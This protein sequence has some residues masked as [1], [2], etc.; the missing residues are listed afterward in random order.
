MPEHHLTNRTDRPVGYYRM[1][2][3]RQDASIERQREGVLPYAKRKYGALLAEYQDE[4]IAGDEFDRRSGFQRLLRDAQAGKFNVLVVDEP[5][6]LS[7]QNLI[8]LVEK[9]IAPLRR[10]RVRIDTVSKGELDYESLPGI[11][12]MAVHAH[13]ASEEVND[14]SRRTLGGMA[15]L[16]QAGRWFGWACPYGLRVIRDVD[17]AT[18]K[19]LS[20]R[21]VFGPD[22][23]VRAVRFIFD[24]VAN[25]GWSLRRVCRELEARRVKPPVGNGRGKNKAGGLWNTPTVRNILKNRK[26][27]GDLP[28]NQRRQGKY[29]AW[30]DG[31]V[32]P[33][34][35]QKQKA[36]RSAP[37]DVVI[38]EVSADV[39][40]PLIDRDTF[41]RAQAALARQQKQTSPNRE[42]NAYL[43]THLAVCGD[44]GSFMRGHPLPA[45]KSYLCSHYKEYGNKA[46]HRNT[47]YEAQLWGAVLGKLK[48]EILSPERLDA[49]EA[50]MERRLK[51]EQRSGE[52]ERLKK[53]IASLDRDVAQGNA[54][55][56]R[57]PEDRLPGVIAQVRAWEKEREGFVA[58]LDDLENGA[59]QLKAVL[60]ECRRQLWRLREALDGEDVEVQAAVVREVV[61]KVEV[62][63]RHERTS[64]RSSPTGKGRVYNIPI[65][66]VVSIRPG[67]GLAEMSCL[68]SPTA[69]AS[70]Q[71]SCPGAASRPRSPRP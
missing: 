19:V 26:Y 6:R 65:R 18:G 3:L 13:K 24:A 14:L 60:A 71:S 55:L 68:F 44:C 21:C 64:G 7:R 36:V 51:A 47:V 59:E 33:S 30:H 69:R 50:E 57:L 42:Q 38:A 34:A 41:A 16:A 10:A 4:G 5:S 9:V 40:P 48:D 31:E 58:R 45:G 15:K 39:L 27:V 62:Y 25:R 37:E 22:E 2:D 8:D 17:P 12:M 20:R 28:W 35:R 1:S 46:C 11:I 54:N 49:I 63:F 23:E 32:K 70:G 53:Q 61:S 66:A 56:A 52:G 67:F 43:F 29:F